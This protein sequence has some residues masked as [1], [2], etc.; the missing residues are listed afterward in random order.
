MGN[1]WESPISAFAD[2]ESADFALQRF[3]NI[4]IRYFLAAKISC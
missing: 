3:E 4:P 1:S 2:V